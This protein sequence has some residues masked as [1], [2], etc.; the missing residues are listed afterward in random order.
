MRIKWLKRSVND[1]EQLFDYIAEDNPQAAGNEVMKA[2]QSAELLSE[3]PY[4]GRAGRVPETREYIVPESP[5]LM[6]YRI[7]SRIMEIL[8]IFHSSRQW[9]PQV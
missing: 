5:Y 2:A 8:R 9:P 4:L 3:N 7:K 1:L 6:I